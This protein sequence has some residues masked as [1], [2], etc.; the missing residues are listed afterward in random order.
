[1]KFKSE[2]RLSAGAST[3][4]G[5]VSERLGTRLGFVRNTKLRTLTLEMFQ[6]CEAIL[7]WVPTH[8]PAL[9]TVMEQRSLPKTRGGRTVSSSSAATQPPPYTEA[10]STPPFA[11]PSVPRVRRHVA[12]PSAE[13]YAVSGQDRPGLVV[14]R[15]SEGLTGVPRDVYIEDKSLFSPDAY[16]TVK[17]KVDEYL[18]TDPP[19]E[20]TG[21]SLID[22]KK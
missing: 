6:I 14:G 7:I 20:D 11:L 12:N 22:R 19:L 9:V 17:N 8:A 18:R 4:R 15:R 2:P 10:V 21:L 1:M 5:L 3:L 13:K 16:I